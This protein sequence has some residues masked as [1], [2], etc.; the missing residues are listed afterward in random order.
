MATRYKSPLDAY[1]K[2]APPPRPA[3]VAT[4][5]AP[6]PKR[7]EKPAESYAAFMSRVGKYKPFLPGDTIEGACPYHSKVTKVYNERIVSICPLCYPE[8][9]ERLERMRLD[10]QTQKGHTD[11]EESLLDD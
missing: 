9:A 10:R 7:P 8:E 11:H 5:R 6:T 1:K 4:V 3:D 2:G